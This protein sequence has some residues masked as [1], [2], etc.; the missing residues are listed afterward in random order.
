MSNPLPEILQQLI[1]EAS[2]KAYEDGEYGCA[3]FSDST[4]EELGHHLDAVAEL[5]ADTLDLDPDQFEEL[6][7]RLAFRVVLLPKQN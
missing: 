5:L 6:E 3:G 7:E 4:E 1:D 2:D